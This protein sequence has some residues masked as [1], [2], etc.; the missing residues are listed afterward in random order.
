MK[1]KNV[2]SALILFQLS[3][4]AMKFDKT[5]LK[6]YLDLL[7]PDSVFDV[8]KLIECSDDSR[9]TL[10]HLASESSVIDA[11]YIKMLLNKGAFIASRVNV[12]D[13]RTPLHCCTVVSDK[14]ALKTSYILEHARQKNIL[15]NVMHLTMGRCAGN[16]AISYRTAPEIRLMYRRKPHIKLFLE[17]GLE[18]NSVIQYAFFIDKLW[19]EEE[20]IE[21]LQFT[22]DII[23]Q[24]IP[25]G[26]NDKGIENMWQYVNEGYAGTSYYTQMTKI[27]TDAQQCIDS[28]I[29][30]PL[31]N[32]RFHYIFLL[33]KELITRLRNFIIQGKIPPTAAKIPMPNDQNEKCILS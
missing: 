3:L 19:T 12:N 18:P 17:Y 28:A 27:I 13:N 8:N 24:S 6:E 14:D 4:T 10:L 32:P 33:P 5:K 26:L 20:R 22:R 16:S 15:Q 23:A 30:D 21:A 31:Q 25:Y 2:F 1:I 9:S 29:W 11:S 7:P